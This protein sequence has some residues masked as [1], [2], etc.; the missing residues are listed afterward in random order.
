MQVNLTNPKPHTLVFLTRGDVQLALG[1]SGLV[2]SFFFLRPVNLLLQSELI[3][4]A[5]RGT[6]NAIKTAVEAKVN[7]QKLHAPLPS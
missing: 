3:D 1:P 6:E 5:V 7:S 4:P 2:F